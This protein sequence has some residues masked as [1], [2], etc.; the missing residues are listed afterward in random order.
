MKNY[1][2]INLNAAYEAAGY[3]G[4]SSGLGMLCS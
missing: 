4:G 1:N 2:N 3:E